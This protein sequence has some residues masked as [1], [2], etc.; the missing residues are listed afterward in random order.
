MGSRP[1]VFGG[2]SGERGEILRFGRKMASN[3]TFF[4]V[5]NQNVILPVLKSFEIMLIEMP[6]VLS[7][8]G[9]QTP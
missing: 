9:C 5:D 2:V 3:S 8:A 7:R 1:E 6:K 4:G